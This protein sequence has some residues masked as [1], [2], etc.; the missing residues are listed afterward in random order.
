VP[1]EKVRIDGKMEKRISTVDVKL[2]Y[3]NQ[4]KFSIECFFDLA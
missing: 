3:T 4:E 2:F 1:L